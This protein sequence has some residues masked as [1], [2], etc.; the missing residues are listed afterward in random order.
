MS[1]GLIMA[2]EEPRI[3]I[4]KMAGP[5]TYDSKTYIDTLLDLNSNNITDVGTLSSGT[6]TTSGTL[7]FTANPAYIRN[8]Q[9][10]SVRSSSA[11]KT[12][13]ALPSRLD[14]TRVMLVQA[15]GVLRL[16]V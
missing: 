1:L 11:P 2:Q 13:L 14:G 7:D 16:P 10:N 8:D 15:R 5:I 4:I 3:L 12:H 9:D 6:I